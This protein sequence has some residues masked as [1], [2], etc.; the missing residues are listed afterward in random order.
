[1]SVAIQTAKF[2]KIYSKSFADIESDIRELSNFCQRIAVYILNDI[3]SNRLALI[4]MTSNKALDIAINNN[5]QTFIASNKVKFLKQLLWVFPSNLLLTSPIIETFRNINSEFYTWITIIF[6]DYI[7]IFINLPF[8]FIFLLGIRFQ[9]NWFFSNIGKFQIEVI[10]YVLYLVLLFIVASENYNVFN[11]TKDEFLKINTLESIFWICNFS[12]IYNECKQLMLNIFVVPDKKKVNILNRHFFK[13]YTNLFDILI[14]ILY[15]LLFI[16]RI[17]AIFEVI[18]CKKV[19]NICGN[20]FL[21]TLY[22][23]IWWCLIMSV[24]CR[25]S[26]MIF[27]FYTM[28]LLIRNL[29]KM[30]FDLLNFITLITLFLLGFAISVFMVGGGTI[31]GYESVSSSFRS[32]F[33]A[34]LADIEWS[35]IT[36]ESTGFTDGRNY[37]IQG[38]IWAWMIFAVLL[39]L[40]FIIAVMTNSYETLTLKA[41]IFVSFHQMRI[42]RSRDIKLPTIPPPL[43]L[44][45]FILLHFFRYLLEPFIYIFFGKF[46]NEEKIICQL[47]KKHNTRQKK[48]THFFRDPYFIFYDNSCRLRQPNQRFIINNIFLRLKYFNIAWKEMKYCLFGNTDNYGHKDSIWIC[49]YCRFTNFEYLKNIRRKKQSDIIRYFEYNDLLPPEFG[50]TDKDLQYLY[51]VNPKLCDNCFR[52]KYVTKRINVIE[53]MISFFIYWFFSFIFLRLPLFIFIVILYCIIFGLLFIFA[54]ISMSIICCLYCCKKGQIFNINVNNDKIYENILLFINKPILFISSTFSDKNLIGYDLYIIIPSKIKEEHFKQFQSLIFDSSENI[55]DWIT[56]WTMNIS[57]NLE[58]RKKKHINSDQP[59][60][61]I[62]NINYLKLIQFKKEM[63]KLSN[64]NINKYK[65]LPKFEIRIVANRYSLEFDDGY[66]SPDALNKIRN[67][68]TLQYTPVL[69][70][71]SKFDSKRIK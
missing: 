64:K 8:M 60:L 32:L 37:L 66:G 55:F 13:D 51:D 57:I 68:Y 67:R 61:L 15:I 5:L 40:N 43:Q 41:D 54:L 46:I 7:R 3:Q 47:N 25:I 58:F 65:P 14:S 45:T 59:I 9:I 44:I 34:V 1:M 39:L 29:L 11:K 4:A 31:K 36:Q 12:F 2:L 28:G 35:V 24:C 30:F 10:T 16:T 17:F 33:F 21:N 50:F 62:K 48:N 42:A 56:R 27:I 70:V 53:S 71:I 49:N 20:S 26:Y 69:S 22:L 18:K 38:I 6:N 52:V 23:Y 63:I 19:D